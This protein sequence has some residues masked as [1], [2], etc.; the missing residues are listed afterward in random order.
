VH[1]LWPQHSPRGKAAISLLVCSARSAGEGDADD[2]VK[3][4]IS[5]QL[6]CLPYVY[7]GLANSEIRARLSQLLSEIA[8]ADITGFLFPSGAGS[9]L[10]AA[11]AH[12]QNNGCE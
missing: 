12:T 5:K 2:Q 6:D 4:A 11:A 10:A 7:S 9:P 8:P 1:E 3:E